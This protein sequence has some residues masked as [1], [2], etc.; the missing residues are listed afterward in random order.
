MS[1]RR[2]SVDR[3]EEKTV[4]AGI[5]KRSGRHGDESRVTIAEASERPRRIMLLGH[6]ARQKSIRGRRRT[7]TVRL[8]S[9]CKVSQSYRSRTVLT[10][11]SKPLALRATGLIYHEGI[12]TNQFYQGLSMAGIGEL[13]RG[14]V[15]VYY[16][17]ITLLHSDKMLGNLF[18]G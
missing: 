7:D 18:P 12:I 16:W 14:V 8:L 6:G 10:T 5:P 9:R 4:Y 3:A 2:C 11:C 17:R 15:A 1:D 13:T